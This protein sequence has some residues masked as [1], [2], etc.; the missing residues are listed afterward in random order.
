[1][2]TSLAARLAELPK[3]KRTA[4][5]SQYS[6]D[7]LD[8]LLHDW[9]F[10]ARPEQLPPPAWE[11]GEAAAW[12]LTGGRGSGK[13]RTGAETAGMLV[14]RHPKVDGAIVAPTFQADALRKCVEGESGILRVIGDLVD[15]YNRSEGV[16]YLKTGATIFATGADN[17][18]VRVQGENLGWC[19]SDEPGL[20][21]RATW[22]L[23]WEES[24]QFAVRKAPALNI[25][26]GT[27]KAGHPLVKML[28]DDASVIKTRMKT[29]DNLDYLDPK[30]AARII[31][32][33]ANTRLGMQELE[34]ILAKEV[35]GALWSWAWIEARRRSDWVDEEGVYV[36]ELVRVVAGVDPSGG[37]NEIG[38]VGAGK[39]KS[40]CPCGL[41]EPM[42][43]HFA[44]LDDVSLL[45]SPEQWGRAVV[46]LHQALSGDRIAA[47]VNFGGDMVESNIRAVDKEVGNAVK[48]LHASRGKQQ[49]AEPISAIYEQ[50]RVH[51]I[52]TFPE[53]ENELISWV[54]GDD[55]SPNRLDALVWALTELADPQTKVRR[56]RVGLGR[57]SP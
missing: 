35:E 23:A 47:E 40:P 21:K 43:P 44:V 3:A 31:A 24:I 52:G 56:A 13:T 55:W 10:W 50:R 8:A 11:R 32:K 6:D 2:S 30:W 22:R 34:G 49:R 25:L 15:N 5:L 19:W 39:I 9:K 4:F 7:E 46:D 18:A 48:V 36:P 38:I 14:R 57:R 1:M 29:I 45:G 17:G 27:P 26:T 53:L 12:W 51:H 42:R 28:E 33:Y 41:E 54:P 37:A 16:I 20:W